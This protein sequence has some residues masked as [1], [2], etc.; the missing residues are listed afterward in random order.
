MNHRNTCPACPARFR[1]QAAKHFR[2][3]SLRNTP[4]RKTGTRASALLRRLLLCPAGR[5]PCPVLG[6]LREQ[7]RAGERSER[8]AAHRR[9]PR[10]VWDVVGA[11]WK[12]VIL[13]EPWFKGLNMVPP[14]DSS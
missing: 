7:R 1:A 4:P 12:R 5:W 2:F 8:W 6:R 9:R 3:A 11:R 10:R 14:N 13:E